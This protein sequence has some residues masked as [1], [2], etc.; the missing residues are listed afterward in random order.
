MR[1]PSLRVETQGRARGGVSGERRT[2]E[3]KPADKEV[4]DAV[5]LPLPLGASRGGHLRRTTGKG[6]TEQGESRVEQQSKGQLG[7]AAGERERMQTPAVR[8]QRK[9]DG[10][11]GGSD[12]EGGAREEGA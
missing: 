8:R 5:Y 4:V 11:T 12:E 1:E 10:R 7:D 6:D 2:A 9:N 3:R